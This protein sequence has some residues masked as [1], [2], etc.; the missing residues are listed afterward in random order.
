M[1]EDPKSATEARSEETSRPSSS[2]RAG[3]KHEAPQPAGSSTTSTT[4]DHGANQQQSKRR[5]GLGVVTPNACTECRKKRAKV[6]RS[7]YLRTKYLRYMVSTYTACCPTCPVQPCHARLAP[8]A[9][10]GPLDLF[11]YPSIHTCIHMFCMGAF[12]AFL[13]S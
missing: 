3:Q 5:R 11:P 4:A 12:L 9:R 10:W 7:S 13:R 1:E 2:S 6:C 8:L